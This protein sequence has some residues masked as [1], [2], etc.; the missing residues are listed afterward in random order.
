MSGT[1]T[2]E[3][4][5][6]R[7]LVLSHRVRRVVDDRMTERGPSLARTKL[8]RVLAEQGRLRQSALAQ[9]LDLAAR[10]VTETVDALERD[11]L[12]A[13][14]PDPADRRAKLVS[15]TDEGSAALDAAHGTGEQVLR[16]IFGALGPEQRETLAG[17]LGLID[18]AT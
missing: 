13:R 16:E 3:E 7:F 17:L 8:L 11:G 6:M 18:R 2:P 5:G 9:R 10:T 12:V 1:V 14:T 4:L 15:L